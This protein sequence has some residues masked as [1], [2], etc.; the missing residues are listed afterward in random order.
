M[1]GGAGIFAPDVTCEIVPR[2]R[3]RVSRTLRREQKE[4]TPHDF[5]AGWD[6]SSHSGS[7]RGEHLVTLCLST[8]VPSVWGEQNHTFSSNRPSH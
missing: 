4:A 6:T 2:S 7:H 1:A 5:M 8:A 3:A